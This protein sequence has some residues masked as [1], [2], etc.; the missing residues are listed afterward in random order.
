M[1][2]TRPASDFKTKGLT[3]RRVPLTVSLYFVYEHRIFPRDEAAK[4]P[5]RDASPPLEVALGA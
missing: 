1:G 2:A 4:K 3:D 5:T